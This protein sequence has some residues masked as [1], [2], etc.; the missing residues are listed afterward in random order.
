M[1]LN[2]NCQTLLQSLRDGASGYSGVMANFH[3][4]L[5]TWLCR[6]YEKEPE[7]AEL[8]QAFLCMSGFTEGLPYPLTAKYPMGLEGIPTEN[9]A[10]N[11]RSEELTEY[12]KS[13]MRQ[14]KQFSDHYTG[15]LYE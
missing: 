11:R 13:C 9:L 12:A 10:R 4:K 6:N 15:R 3:P 14:M 5:Y 1:L 7:Q 2:A 8:L